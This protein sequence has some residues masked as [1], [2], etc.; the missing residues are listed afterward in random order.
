LGD[1]G[2]KAQGER[3]LVSAL[4]FPLCAGQLRLAL[5]LLDGSQIR[6]PHS[7]RLLVE[8]EGEEHIASTA[9]HAR[10][11]VEDRSGEDDRGSGRGLEGLRA[12]LGKRNLAAV[13][14]RVEIDRDGEPAMRNR[15]PGVVAMRTEMPAC[16]GIVASGT[17]F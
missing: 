14:I 5:R 3:H 7:L 4:R 8:K 2:T 13:E 15:D 17:P 6:L 11:L 16:L 1:R 10:H 9:R 12:V